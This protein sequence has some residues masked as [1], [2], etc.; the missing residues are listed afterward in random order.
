M[1]E[2]KWTIR[3]VKYTSVSK[4]EE[5]DLNFSNATAS[6]TTSKFRVSAAKY[7]NYVGIA[8][9]RSLL[10]SNV[11]T[12]K[13]QMISFKSVVDVI[14]MSKNV[15]VV[16]DSSV[17]LHF[18]TY[19]GRTIHSQPLP[20]SQGPFVSIHIHDNCMHVLTKSGKCYVFSNLDLKP[21]IDEVSSESAIKTLKSKMKMRVLDVGKTPRFLVSKENLCA[22]MTHLDL[23]IWRHECFETVA[24]F[25]DDVKMASW[26]SSASILTLTEAGTSKSTLYLVDTSEKEICD[27][28]ELSWLEQFSVLYTDDSKI[29]VVVIRAEPSGTI[30]EVRDL[31]LSGDTEIVYKLQTKP[32]SC[33]LLSSSA[34]SSND[35]VFFVIPH[36][37]PGIFF[38]CERSSTMLS[39]SHVKE[40]LFS[41]KKSLLLSKEILAQAHETLSDMP[42]NA[43]GSAQGIETT[44]KTEESLELVVACCL[45][46]S[47]QDHLQTSQVLQYALTRCTNAQRK[48]LSQLVSDTSRLLV[49]FVCCRREG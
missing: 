38:R 11:V 46:A 4:N 29:R 6:R 45:E 14:A 21:L 33:T 13:D 24:S 17:V 41:S 26:C 42:F 12:N 48:D 19:E 47:L 16:G 34:S 15:I 49:T 2:D 36:N 20:P 22:V 9:E 27:V 3:S 25:E 28:W 39:S 18:V 8:R 31:L 37:T 1:M 30:A 35:Q 23:K 43:S 32:T 7:E 10:I 5:N 40:Q 44:L